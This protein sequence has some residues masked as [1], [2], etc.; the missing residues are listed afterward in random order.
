MREGTKEKE[1][2]REKNLT[3]TKLTLTQNGPFYP[4]FEIFAGMQNHDLLTC[5]ALVLGSTLHGAKVI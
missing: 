5:A 4:F 2:E 3:A 1:R